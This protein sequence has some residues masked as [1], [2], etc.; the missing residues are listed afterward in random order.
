[1][2]PRRLA[3]DRSWLKRVQT[4]AWTE[5]NICR[6]L[7]AGTAPWPALIP[8]GHMGVFGAAVDPSGHLPNIAAAEVLQGRAIG[9]EV[10]RGERLGG[11]IPLERLPEESRAALRSRI[12]GAKLSC[13]APS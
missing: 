4:E 3:S 13:T 11:A 5:A 2:Y 1:M 10:I 8:E 7:I 12:L 6:L 9:A